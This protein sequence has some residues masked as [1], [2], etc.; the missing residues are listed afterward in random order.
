MVWLIISWKEKFVN[1]KSHLYFRIF[2]NEKRKTQSFLSIVS[3]VSV[4][5][6]IVLIKQLLRN[7]I[8]AFC[9][10]QGVKIHKRDLLKH[11]GMVYRFVRVLSPSKRSVM[12]NQHSGDLHR[13]GKAGTGGE[14]RDGNIFPM[15]I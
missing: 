13:C 2:A 5:A 9:E 14:K 1:S 10:C 12:L 4:L 11:N 6:Q 7:G 15:R 3:I 8:N